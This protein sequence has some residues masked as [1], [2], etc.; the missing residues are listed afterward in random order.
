ME[1]FICVATGGVRFYYFRHFVQIGYRF[2]LA[3]VSGGRMDRRGFIRDVTQAGIAVPGLMI[4]AG[5]STA[6]T[7]NGQIPGSHP[8]PEGLKSGEIFRFQTP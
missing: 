6:A 7:V 4:D 1:E 3:P 5:P 2:G 8:Q